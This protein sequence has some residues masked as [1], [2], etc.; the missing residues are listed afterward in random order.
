VISVISADQ[1]GL[2]GLTVESSASCKQIEVC[3]K[4]IISAFDGDLP[5]YT[6]SIYTLKNA[7]LF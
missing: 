5:Q 2:T 6:P 3:G 1:S 7:G 4:M